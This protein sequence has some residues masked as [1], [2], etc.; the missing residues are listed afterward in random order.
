M[1]LE[2]VG[3]NFPLTNGARMN[4]PY[5]SER[6]LGLVLQDIDAHPMSSM[7]ATAKRTG[8]PYQSVTRA[9]KWANM[10]GTLVRRTIGGIWGGHGK[11]YANFLRPE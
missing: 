1:I 7:K 8:L 5:V 4:F 6:V 3:D 10:E 2:L 11:T 9:C